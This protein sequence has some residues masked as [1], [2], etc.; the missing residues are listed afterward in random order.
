MLILHR[1]YS[2]FYDLLTTHFVHEDLVNH[3]LPNVLIYLGATLLLYLF[4]FSQNEKKLFYKLF[5]TNCLIVPFIISL[6]WIP[7]NRLI[8][9]W[10][11]RSFGFSGVVSA[12]LGTLVFAYVLFL[13]RTLKVDTLYSYLS[14][15]LFV[16]LI[17]VLIYFTFTESIIITAS[18][19]LLFFVLFAYQTMKS[20]DKQV[21]M[22]LQEK[23]KNKIIVYIIVSILYLLILIFSL[24]LFP[25]QFIQE[26]TTVNF[27]IHYMGFIL[28]IGAAQLIWQHSNHNNYR[29]E[30]VKNKA[31]C[32]SVIG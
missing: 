11:P 21:K 12:F 18:L 32:E 22:K 8:W 29:N 2:N 31:C 7:V 10:A 19:L 9:T 4:L 26:N 13:H 27:L 3:L 23:L 20:I 6:L 24:S 1:D 5:I 30:K 14:S 17:F 15:I 25:R 16:A 28:G